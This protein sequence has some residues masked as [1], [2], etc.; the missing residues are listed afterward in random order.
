MA[1]RRLPYSVDPTSPQTPGRSMLTVWPAIAYRSVPQMIGQTVSHYR[2]LEEIGIGGMGVVYRAEDTALGRYVALKFLPESIVGDRQAVERFKREARAAAALNHPNICSIH[3]IGEYEGQPFIVM[4]LLRGQTLR[5]KLARGPL[6]P[7]RPVS[8]GM[9]LADALDAAHAE[10]IIHRDIKPA[11]IF[12]TDRQQIKILDFGLAK[13]IQNDD[14]QLETDDE[15]AVGEKSSVDLTAVG[16]TV[17]TIAYM[18]P[19]QVLGRTLDARADLFSLGVVLYETATGRPTFAGVNR[20]ATFDAILH[21][22]PTLAIQLSPDI[23]SHLNDVISELLEKSPALRFQTAANLHASL[24]RA[25]RQPGTSGVRKPRRSVAVLSFVDMSS[26]QDQEYFCDGLAEELIGSLA[27]LNGLSVASRTSTF[28]FKGKDAD[29]R[30]IGGQ[31]NVE[32]V[33]EGSVRKVGDRLRVTAQLVNVA[34]GYNLWSEKYEREVGDVFAIYDEIAQAIVDKLQV[35]LGDTTET[36]IVRRYTD[37]PDAYNAYLKGRYFWNRRSRGLLRKA[38]QYFEQAARLDPSFALAHTGLADSYTVLGIYS[39]LPPEEAR[40]KAETA[41][42][43]ALAVDADLV[44]ARTS[45][46]LIKQYFN[47]DWEGAE[48]DFRRTIELD[49][50]YALARSYYSVLLVYLNRPEEARRQAD[51]GI[52]LDP[53]SV[54]VNSLAAISFYYMG[55]Y[56]RALADCD[57]ALELE[58]D[59]LIALWVRGSSLSELGKH[60][61]AVASLEKA[62]E[63]SEGGRF[64]IAVL[65]VTYALAGRKE[66]AAEILDDLIEKAKNDFV[67][68]FLVCLL[69]E[70]LGNRELAFEHLMEAY[71]QR[72]SV[73]C[74]LMAIPHLSGMRS[75]PRYLDLAQRVGLVKCSRSSTAGSGSKSAGAGSAGP[76]LSPRP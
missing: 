36:P 2:I 72:S 63:I 59:C 26:R 56:G 27:R 12:V 13:W 45:R 1:G 62:V 73:L 21:V 75:D 47:W 23:G 60:D 53:L 14:T 54:M 40:A 29:I 41:V 68:P 61:P 5:E 20:A 71:R 19:E 49:P 55:D 39:A 24:A 28:A 64:F 3:D 51:A 70:G 30:K 35:T 33:L 9:Q 38:I 11:N 6:P 43:K 4:E 65:G 32:S 67:D 17:G 25:K 46:A 8:V 22:Q 76:T 42:M 15:T 7:D 16:T 44:E 34:D 58:P 66:E 18:A 69:Y 50:T 48:R 31:L 74:Q 52:Q 57:T 10:G 37:N